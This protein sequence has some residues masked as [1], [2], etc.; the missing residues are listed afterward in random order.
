MRTR[1]VTNNLATHPVS[2]AAS[3]P[4]LTASNPTAHVRPACPLSSG[5]AGERVRGPSVESTVHR[6]ITTNPVFTTATEGPPHP[7]PLPPK[8]AGEGTGITNVRCRTNRSKCPGADAARLAKISLRRGFSL[9]ELMVVISI[10]TVLFG[11]VGVVFHRLFLAEQVAMRAALTERTVSRLADQFRRDVHATSGADRDKGD[12]GVNRTLKLMQIEIDRTNK[13]FPAIVYSAREGEVI[14]EQLG[15][16]DK[17]LSRE[18]YRLPECRVSFPNQ[19]DEVTHEFDGVMLSLVIERQGSTIT[20]QPQ[21][22]RPRRS[23][24]IEAFLGRDHDLALGLA[25]STAKDLKEESK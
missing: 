9:I 7:Y 3:A 17:L 13:N 14:R 1:H 15:G 5:S 25:I 10:I 24:V 6:G 12:D 18:I 11:M 4:G 8:R 19:T 21:A 16:D 20:P 23:L 22:T 2:R